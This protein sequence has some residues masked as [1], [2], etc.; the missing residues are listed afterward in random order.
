MTE[1]T[2]TQGWYEWDP[3][4]RAQ[5]AKRVGKAHSKPVLMP[6]SEYVYLYGEAEYRGCWVFPFFR[7]VQT[8]NGMT[9]TRTF[10][11]ATHKA[12]ER[13]REGS[14]RGLDP[15]RVLSLDAEWSARALR[16]AAKWEKRTGKAV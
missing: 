11:M 12:E 3:P 10:V 14:L 2:L 15:L 7:P 16:E 4:S 1:T 8:R 6:F 9:L 13:V 5:Q